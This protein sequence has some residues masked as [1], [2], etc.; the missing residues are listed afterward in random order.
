MIFG[1]RLVTKREIALWMALAE[2]QKQAI[3]KLEKA[4]EKERA[5]ADAAINLLL[6]RT[7]GAVIRPEPT[8]MD[9]ERMESHTYDLFDDSVSAQVKKEAKLLEEIQG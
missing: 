7:Q 3:A 4:V 6:A 8:E 2:E 5:R 9:I 1:L